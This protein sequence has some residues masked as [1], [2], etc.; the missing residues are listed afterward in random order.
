[1][2]NEKSKQP[3]QAKGK[4]DKPPSQDALEEAKLEELTADTGAGGHAAVIREVARLQQDTRHLKKQNLRVWLVAGLLAVA[5]I[6]GMCAAFFW[7]PKYRYIPT[8]DNAAICEV[9]TQDS[10]IVTPATLEDFAREAT[11]NSYSYDYINY[12][13]TIGDVT[14]RFYSERGRKAFMGSLDQSGNLERVVKGLLIMKAFATNSPQL[15]SEGREGAYRFWIVRVP[16]AIEFYTGG[17]ATPSSSQDFMAEVKIMQE[18]AS[19][20][21]P[22]GIAID[23]IVLKP[24]TRGK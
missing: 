17:N 9:G 22:K 23:S 21:N 6:I 5:L 24:S 16:I 10:S 2:S 1:M 12:R 3:E 13:S 8:I 18:Q 15:E 19:K 20:M 7:F 14:N 11:V 4:A